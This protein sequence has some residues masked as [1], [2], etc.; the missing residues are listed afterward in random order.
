[1]I[2]NFLLFHLSGFYSCFFF[3]LLFIYISTIL[4][5]FFVFLFLL[6]CFLFF[7][8]N[9]MNYCV[10]FAMI[11]L[12]FICLLCQTPKL[13]FCF[14]EHELGLRAISYY[15][16]KSSIMPNPNLENSQK[17]QVQSLQQQQQITK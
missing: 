12:A 15:Y 2:K 1:M 7:L 16:L 13:E 6:F 9:S 10:C 8:A 11:Y 5:Y 14:A 3:Y 17:S 4:L